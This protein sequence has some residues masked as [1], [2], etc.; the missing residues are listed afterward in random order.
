MNFPGRYRPRKTDRFGSFRGGYKTLPG[1]A[2]HPGSRQDR[3]AFEP[4][5]GRLVKDPRVDFVPPQA[6]RQLEVERGERGRIELRKAAV[7]K[8]ELPR[9]RCVQIVD[10][11]D[12]TA[13]ACE[14]TMALYPPSRRL[15][16]P[17]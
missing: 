7:S 17:L 6:G 9:F 13:G 3:F 11:A 1:H 4:N 16:F 14:R 5:P 8:G 10:E 12:R 15:P 2:G